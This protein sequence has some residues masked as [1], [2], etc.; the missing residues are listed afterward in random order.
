M[1][2]GR[3]RWPTVAF[4]P[5]VYVDDEGFHLFFT[6]VFCGR[7][8]GYF[9][10]WNPAN[11]LGC[12]IIRSVGS[13]AYAFSGDQGRTWQ[14]R[15]TP[16]VLPGDSGFDSAKIETA[17][18][19]RLGDTL[20]LTYSTDGD[21]A[22][23][24]MTGRFQIGLAT[25]ALEGRSVREVMMD[26]SIRFA[27]RP[28]P[29]LP[30]DLS[31]GRFDNNVQEPSVVVSP[32]GIYLYY[33]GLGLRLPD[34]PVDAPGQEIASIGLGRALLDPSLNVISRSSS[35]LVRGANITEV[36]YFDGAYHLFGT[37]VEPSEAT[38]EFHRG[39]RISYSTSADGV[40]WSPSATIL[41]QTVP[42][43][44]EWG[45]MAPTAAVLKDRVVLFYTAYTVGQHP[46]FP[47]PFY[48]RF[49]KPVLNG[50]QCLF[51]TI[52]RAVA[53]RTNGVLPRLER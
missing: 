14:F 7:E 36:R 30:S 9:Y 19:F 4:D 37:T 6:N 24:R 16:A 29:W 45:L 49:G 47:V 35:A 32:E 3:A 1:S 20:H 34:E 44:D 48:G 31:P 41:R 38:G 51:P 15:P 23:R 5:G 33:V 50:S 42:G 11:Q 21:R 39:D 18:V 28:T 8:N 46:C 27:R 40:E 53:L 2:S 12:D 10:S 22:G 43:L 25:I 13:I 52:G 26:D 17:F